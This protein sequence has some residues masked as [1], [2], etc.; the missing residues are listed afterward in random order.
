[1]GRAQRGPSGKVSGPKGPCEPNGEGPEGPS[2]KVSGPFTTNERAQRGPCGK[3]LFACFF[4]F[5]YTYAIFIM[6]FT[7]LLTTRRGPFWA[8]R[9]SHGPFGPPPWLRPCRGDSLTGYTKRLSLNF[10][11]L[12]IRSGQFCGLAIMLV[13]REKLHFTLFRVKTIPNIKS[14]HQ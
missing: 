8:P 10:D 1:M 6:P 11:I 7:V 13:T 5:H 14:M 4:I 12:D 2:N 3:V 9:R